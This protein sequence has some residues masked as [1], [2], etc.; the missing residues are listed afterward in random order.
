M[1]WGLAAVLVL[2]VGCLAFPTYNR[3]QFL[4]EPG[5]VLKVSQNADECQ[6]LEGIVGAEDSAIV[7]ER[8]VIFGS[9]DRMTLREKKGGMEI[10]QNGSLV[11]VFAAE[12]GETKV[13]TLSLENFPTDVDFHPHGIHL[14]R[15]NN[16]MLLFVINHAYTAGGERVELAR[17]A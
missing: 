17:E 13:A 4:F 5:K 11:V 10:V 1:R 7:S 9:D 15:N 8:I 12:N 2:L 16:Q 14:L 3:F 6:L